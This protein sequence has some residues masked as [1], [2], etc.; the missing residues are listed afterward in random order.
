VLQAAVDRPGPGGDQSGDQRWRD[1]RQERAD[2][3]EHERVVQLSTESGGRAP[4]GDLAVDRL[5]GESMGALQV[6]GVVRGRAGRVVGYVPD[7]PAVLCLRGQQDVE[8]L[9]SPRPLQVR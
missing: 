4:G 6:V 7:I 1:V 2:G 9:R 5:G 3:G 8:I